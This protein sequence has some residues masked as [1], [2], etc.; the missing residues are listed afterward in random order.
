MGTEIVPVNSRPGQVLSSREDPPAIVTAA[1]GAA[2][3]AWDEFFAGSV[4]NPHTRAAY[5]RAVRQFLD[6][7]SSQGLELSHI[8][9]GLVGAYFNEHPGSIPTKKQAIAA[10]RG[11]FDTL[12]TR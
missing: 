8:T 1:G 12:V 11:L 3:F 4:R 6:W 7:V 5:T 10:I 2:A 9:P